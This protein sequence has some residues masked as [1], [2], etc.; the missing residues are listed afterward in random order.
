MAVQRQASEERPIIISSRL[1]RKCIMRIF[2]TTLSSHTSIHTSTNCLVLPFPSTFSSLHQFVWVCRP[3]LLF[4]CTRSTTSKQALFMKFPRWLTVSHTSHGNFE[5][6]SFKPGRFSRNSS[7]CFC[8][9]FGT[10][11]PP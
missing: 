10:Y 5:Y 9:T 1:I 11:M 6:F 3:C 8:N 2:I 7:I 4:I